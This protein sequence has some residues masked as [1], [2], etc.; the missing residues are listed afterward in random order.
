[1]SFENFLVTAKCFRPVDKWDAASLRE[2]LKD[3]FLTNL[4][5]KNVTTFHSVSGT[6]PDSKGIPNT[7]Q[8]SG[9]LRIISTGVRFKQIVDADQLR[10]FV[11]TMFHLSPCS[12]AHWYG[13][14][15]QIRGWRDI[16]EVRSSRFFQVLSRDTGIVKF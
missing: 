1:M 6:F 8:K 9:T 12:M 3:S 16:G 4:E 10:R 11:K 15:R 2:S 5:L 14:Y 13:Q 7:F